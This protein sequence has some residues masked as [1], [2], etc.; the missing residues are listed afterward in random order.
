MK[1]WRSTVFK[2][3]HGRII[4]YVSGAITLLGCLRDVTFYIIAHQQNEKTNRKWVWLN[5][6]DGQLDNSCEVN[7]LGHYLPDS[8]NALTVTH[9]VSFMDQDLLFSKASVRAVSNE[10]AGVSISASQRIFFWEDL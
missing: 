6:Y 3:G 2:D 5:T 9:V 7:V 1:E 10:M 8:V 4:W